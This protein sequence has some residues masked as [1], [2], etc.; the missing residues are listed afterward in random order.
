MG[1]SKDERRKKLEQISRESHSRIQKAY[2]NPDFLN[3]PDARLIRMLSE[4]LEPERRF[5]LNKIRDFIVFFG[6]AR[7]FPEEPGEK[8][9]EGAPEVTPIT[10][11][12]RRKLSVFYERGRLLAKKL[13]EWSLGLPG[14]HDRFVICSGGGPGMMEAANRGAQEGGG[15]SVG[16][17]ISLP[18]E[19]EPN[20]YIPKNLSL[21]FHYFFMRKFWFVYLSRAMVIM[22]GGFGT[23][24]EMLEVLTLVQT[25]K[26]KKSLPIV[27]MGREYWEEVMDFQALLRWGTISPED[28]NLFRIIDDVDEAFDYLTSELD[29]LY[30][31][32]GETHAPPQIQ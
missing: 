25:G 4:Y 22:P 18:F 2:R 30:L 19:Q 16:L 21:E 5:R 26:L 13:T 15:R 1:R 31:S 24:D 9:V 6:S 23:L 11:A 28:L 27:L 32:K 14:K 10:N 17:N 20:P 8:I 29:R 7:A 12:Y 3:S